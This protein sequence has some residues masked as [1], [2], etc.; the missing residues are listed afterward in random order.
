MKTILYL[1][2][3]KYVA[4]RRLAGIREVAA[5][6]S[7]FVAAVDIDAISAKRLL[8]YWKPDGAIVEGF[9][10]RRPGWSEALFDEAG[11]PAVFCDAEEEISPKPRFAVTHD[12]GEA[13]RLAMSEL[14]SLGLPRYAYVHQWQLFDWSARREDVFR[15]ETAAAGVDARVFR[16]PAK[17]GMRDM[18]ALMES[19]CAFL[20]TLPTPCGVLAANDETASLVLLAAAR[21]GLSVPWDLAVAGIGND[22][23]ICE[24]TRPTLTSVASAFIQSGRLAATLLKRRLDDPALPPETLEFGCAPL[25]RRQS[26]DRTVRRDPKIARAQELIRRKACEGLAPPEVV[27]T[28]GLATRSAE[29]RFKNATGKSIRDAILAA[30]VARAMALLSEPRRDPV[31]V[32]VECGWCDD[33]A[34]RRAFVQETGLTPLRWRRL[35][36][37]R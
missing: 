15:E 7:W 6:E 1:S 16:P 18:R 13:A 22:T 26:T 21:C 23:D 34:F 20:S 10:L 27:K 19:L 36:F 35:H 4:R 3:M 31:S 9:V 29:I 8:A 37:G 2:G 25:V 32:F 17:R 11:V 24:T 14:L 28:M 12:S 30:R 33:H 5:A